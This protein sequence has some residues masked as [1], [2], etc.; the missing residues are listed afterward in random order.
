MLVINARLSCTPL[1]TSAQ[2]G[3]LV[4]K[5]IRGSRACP[6]AWLTVSG[7]FY[8]KVCETA[9]VTENNL[10]ILKY[11]MKAWKLR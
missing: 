1:I 8:T 7:F 10:E 5:L 2:E 11:Q 4:S 3:Q 6:Q 9:S